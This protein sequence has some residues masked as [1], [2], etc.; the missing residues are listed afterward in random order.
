MTLKQLEDIIHYR[1]KL[2]GVF[3]DAERVGVIDPNG[4]LFDTVWR[5]IEA[6]TCVVDPYDWIGW[7]A[8]ENEYGKNGLEVDIGNKTIKVKSVKDLYTA[9]KRSEKL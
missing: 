8:N 4:P 3:R 7:F 5:S 6:I 1:K 9:I 2:N